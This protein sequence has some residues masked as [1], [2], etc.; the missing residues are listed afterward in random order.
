[1]HHILVALQAH[2]DLAKLDFEDA[3]ARRFTAERLERPSSISRIMVDLRAEQQGPAGANDADSI[4]A[5]LWI[6]AHDAADLAGN[7]IHDQLESVA[8][9]IAGW[10]IDTRPVRPI[11][12]TWPG[13]STP[14]LKVIILLRRETGVAADGFAAAVDEAVDTAASRMVA[15]SLSRH[16]VT[17]E[18]LRAPVLDAVAT[19]WFPTAARVDEAVSLGVFEPFE[20]SDTFDR[21]ATRRLVVFEHRLH[22]NPNAW[23]D[24]PDAVVAAKG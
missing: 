19:L 5:L 13:S 20:R 1:M 6:S 14:G 22:P 8:S 16:L 12:V 23:F 17:G 11:E 7:V 3:V 4:D 9:T 10:H 18:L 15:G 2:Q 21:A 24:A